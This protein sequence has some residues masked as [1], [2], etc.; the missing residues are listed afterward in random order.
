VFGQVGC[1]K[2]SEIFGIGQAE[3]NW[4][5]IKANKFW[6]RSNLSSMKIKKQAIISAAYSRQ[7]VEACHKTAQKSSML[8]TD[9]VFDYCKIDQYCQGSIVDNFN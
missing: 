6:K 3:Q 4:K 5:A 2:W 8:W 1:F 7:K 9:E